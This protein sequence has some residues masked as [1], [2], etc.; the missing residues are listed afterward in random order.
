LIK[1][2]PALLEMMKEKEVLIERLPK[3]MTSLSGECE[4]CGNYSDNL[5]EKDSA[6]VCEDCR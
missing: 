4:I 5:R 2:E 6:I 3:R 1:V